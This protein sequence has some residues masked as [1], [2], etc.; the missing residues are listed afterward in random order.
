MAE[1]T[2]QQ[3]VKAQKDIVSYL[4]H[5]CSTS[6]N[7]SG[8][9]KEYISRLTSEGGIYE[10]QQKALDHFSESSAKTKAEADNMMQITQA[11]STA[12]HNIS[13]EFD[14]LNETIKKAQKERR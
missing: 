13:Q 9:L 3:L 12:L 1:Y 4:I 10:T 11:N 8:F 7:I 2:E 14:K 5:I 6:S